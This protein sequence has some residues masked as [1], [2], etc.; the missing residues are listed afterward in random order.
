MAVILIIANTIMTPIHML[1]NKR[2]SGFMIHP[3]ISIFGMLTMVTII[4]VIV[5]MLAMS[6]FIIHMSYMNNKSDLGGTGFMIRPIISIFGMLIIP[7]LPPTRDS[8]SPTS[9]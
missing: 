9:S 8:P 6:V 5:F 1:E 7:S 3:I 4:I 2:I